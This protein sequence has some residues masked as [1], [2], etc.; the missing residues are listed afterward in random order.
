MITSLKYGIV[1]NNSLVTPCTQPSKSLSKTPFQ[2]PLDLLPVPH[3]S[4]IKT[5]SPPPLDPRRRPPL[6]VLKDPCLPRHLPFLQPRQ[7]LGKICWTLTRP[8]SGL[9]MENR[10]RI[11]RF[12][13]MITHLPKS[14]GFWRESEWTLVSLPWKIRCR[15]RPA[16]EPGAATFRSGEWK[17]GEACTDIS[18]TDS[19]ATVPPAANTLP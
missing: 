16:A 15:G 1:V 8:F 12:D 17:N 13:H 11:I 3:N 18:R 4:C 10:G 7:F 5:R 2:G 9:R 6:I 19:L 14:P